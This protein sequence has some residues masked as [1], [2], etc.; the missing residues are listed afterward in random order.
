[1]FQ[2]GLATIGFTA[3]IHLS[4]RHYREYEKLKSENSLL[5]ER[6]KKTIDATSDQG[7]Q[8]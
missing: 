8:D 3:V 7:D 4:F 1:M 6:W 2:I 5:R